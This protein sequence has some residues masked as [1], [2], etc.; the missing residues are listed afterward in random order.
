MIRRAQIHGSH[1]AAV[2]VVS[3]HLDALKKVGTVSSVASMDAA[4]PGTADKTAQQHITSISMASEGHAYDSEISSEKGVHRLL[5]ILGIPPLDITES[6][7]IQETLDVAASNRLQRI[8]NGSSR[9]ES[10]ID[11]VL[12]S[13]LN[14]SFSAQQLLLDSL[15]ADTTH[16]TVQMFNEET[17]SRIKALELSV[18]TIGA[19]MA[20]LNLENLHVA[21]KEREQFVK[22]WDL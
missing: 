20:N 2:I 6:R 15:L 17:R 22:T 12:A 19:G 21:N 13:H 8:G 16:R 1:V 4:A 18:G 14:E 10:T 3:S 9:L 7:D 5:H 11:S